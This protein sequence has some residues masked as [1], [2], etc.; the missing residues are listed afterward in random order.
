MSKEAVLESTRRDA[1]YRAQAEH[2]LA[3][4][5]RILKRLASERRRHEPRR[6]DES[7]IVD[8]VKAILSGR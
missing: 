3:E 1:H 2:C 5:N 4:T 8:E 7:N 6:T